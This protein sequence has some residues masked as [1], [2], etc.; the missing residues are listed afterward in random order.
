MSAHA[1]LSPSAAHRWLNCPRSARL[2][3]EL[4]EKVSVY[5]EEGTLAHSVCEFTAKKYF[6]KIAPSTYS[7]NLKKFKS[8]NLWNDE[9]LS[10]LLEVTC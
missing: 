3:A 8:E 1:L 5:A 10:N 6:K 2:E 7:R 4:P 9:M